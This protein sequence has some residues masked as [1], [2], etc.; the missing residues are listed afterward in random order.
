[1]TQSYRIFY[2]SITLLRFIIYII[3]NYLIWREGQ[4]RTEVT[5]GN[6]VNGCTKMINLLCCE[7]YLQIAINFFV[8]KFSSFLN[9]MSTHASS[10]KIIWQKCIS[11]S[12]QLFCLRLIVTA[13]FRKIF[14]SVKC[15]RRWSSWLTCRSFHW[16]LSLFSLTNLPLSSTCLSR[17]GTINLYQNFVWTVSSITWRNGRHCETRS[18]F[19][20]IFIICVS[21][22]SWCI[23]V[24]FWKW[25][26]K[27]SSDR[28]HSFGQMFGNN[29]IIIIS[30]N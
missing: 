10:K 22:V 12:M 8:S 5:L 25:F 9:F 30:V 17:N 15:D 13:K 19:P 2:Y 20:V 26:R 16:S 29:W 6:S 28:A 14:L 3:L 24:L 23:T 1:M 21:V 18:T 27:K 11:C 7:Y 4:K